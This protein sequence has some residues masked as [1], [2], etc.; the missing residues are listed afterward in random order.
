MIKIWKVAK[1]TEKKDFS[2]IKTYGQLE[3]I[4][5]M[6]LSK[7]IIVE[8]IYGKKHNIKTLS[9]LA[10]IKNILP[11]DEIRKN[12][13]LGKKMENKNYKILEYLNM[14]YE[15]IT[16][17][18][19]K[20]R[21]RSN[22]TDINFLIYKK[23][24]FN[25]TNYYE[26]AFFFIG[27]TKLNTIY[28]KEF[29]LS[30]KDEKGNYTKSTTLNN[31]RLDMETAEEKKEGKLFFKELSEILTSLR[32]SGLK[33][34][35]NIKNFDYEHETYRLN[36]STLNGINKYWS[37]DVTKKVKKSEKPKIGT[38][39]KNAEYI[40]NELIGLSEG[41]IDIAIK[42]I[43]FFINRAGKNLKNKKEILRAKKI[44]QDM[45]QATE[46][47]AVAGINEIDYQYDNYSIYYDSANG[48]VFFGDNQAE[49]EA[50]LPYEVYKSYKYI[51][52]DFNNKH[53]YGYC[54]YAF[55][56]RKYKSLKRKKENHVMMVNSQTD[57]III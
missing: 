56:L 54:C 21:I 36:N 57:D 3:T 38:F 39:T 29:V 9:Q 25:T 51:V 24:K 1:L 41:D 35:T 15:D 4:I 13:Q 12:M 18:T 47:K 10:K 23:E 32:N 33:P 30:N 37:Q 17:I 7:Y 50:N 19:Y 52:V 27:K 49:I 46:M 11:A 48:L 45:N 53:A 40:V 34:E 55:A 8:D 28:V 44:L 31:R 22:S 43:Q 5:A 6:G 16:L 26:I 42:K 20:K 14:G 2:E